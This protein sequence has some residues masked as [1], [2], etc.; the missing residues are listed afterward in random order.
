MPKVN[1]WLI[2]LP[3]VFLF[4][5]LYEGSLTG[6][7]GM[8]ACIAK[9]MLLNGN[10]L[11]P[12][13]PDGYYLNKPPGFFWIL[14]FSFNLFGFTTFAAR[15]PVSLFAVLDSLILF[16][17]VKRVT[18]DNM[19]AFIA[20]GSFVVN[21]LILRFSTDVRQE[22]LILLINLLAFT[23]LRPNFLNS[24]FYGLI[25][26]FGFL[27]K[28][29]FVLPGVISVSLVHLIK[30]RYRLL[31][32]VGLSLLLGFLIF[33][34]YLAYVIKVQPSFLRVFFEEQILQRISGQLSEGRPRP[35]YY[36]EWVFVKYLFPWNLILISVLIFRRHYVWQYFKNELVVFST[37]LFFLFFF[38]LHLVSIK[39]L[40][41][42]YYCVPFI[43]ILIALGLKDSHWNVRVA[44]FLKGA[45]LLFGGAA[46][47]LP[48]HF[49]KDGLKDLKPLVEVSLSSFKKVSLS[50]SFDKRTRYSVKFYYDSLVFDPDKADYIIHRCQK[51]N[52]LL[53]YRKFCLYRNEHESSSGN[54]GKRLERRN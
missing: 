21:F 52:A 12:H 9:D 41:Y 26:G 29:P 25:L 17:I 7:A 14:A 53:R 22:S 23:L 11:I 28:G 38:P 35:F 15:F 37:L 47:F 39:S 44:S 34:I 32:Y 3:F 42:F 18:K 49:H 8:Y 50:D 45:T 54:N 27:V 51:G 20:V 4:S 16:Y 2:I 43:S 33:S 46:L 10:W 19:A 40:R 1:V 24:F 6:D 30:R 13:L 31:Y 5:R 36:Y 48:V